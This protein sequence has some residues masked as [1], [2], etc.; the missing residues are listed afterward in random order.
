MTSF[1][2]L[3]EIQRNFCEAISKW[4]DLQ[5]VTLLRYVI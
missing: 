3:F 1:G 4:D 2:L 5:M